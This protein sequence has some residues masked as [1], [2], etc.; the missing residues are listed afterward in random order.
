M[1]PRFGGVR[2]KTAGGT[3][4]VIKADDIVVWGGFGKPT[5]C[6]PARTD[7][8]ALQSKEPPLDPLTQQ[9]FRGRWDQLIGPLF[10]QDGEPSR[11]KMEGVVREWMLRN[12][13][14]LQKDIQIR[15]TEE[16]EA[17][18]WGVRAYAVLRAPWSPVQI[19]HVRMGVDRDRGWGLVASTTIRKD[20]YLYEV[21]GALTVDMTEE[22]TDL[23]TM[24]VY[25]GKTRIMWGPLRLV[26]HDCEPNIEW[27][28]VTGSKNA[29]VGRA[30]RTIV[31]GDQLLADYG[32]GYFEGPCPCQSCNP[33]VHGAK[34][35]E[36]ME[37]E[38]AAA[39][40]ERKR[41]RDRENRAKKKA[42]KAKSSGGTGIARDSHGTGPGRAGLC[43]RLGLAP[44]NPNVPAGRDAEPITRISAGL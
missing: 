9:L 12:A 28:R 15:S 7:A 10:A 24:T 30:I 35:R 40:R 11:V 27:V 43:L 42:S 8:V 34:S 1:Y 41:R 38:V 23:S 33:E 17:L 32:R 29:L 18:N 39:K 4:T 16:F 26:N 6:A 31:G 14:W 22:Q 20:E 13:G 2:A 3:R 21:L 19:K 44:S 37:E 5:G 36:E 25:G